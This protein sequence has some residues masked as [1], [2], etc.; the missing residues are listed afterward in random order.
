MLPLSIVKVSFCLLGL[1]SVLFYKARQVQKIDKTYIF[2]SFLL[3]FFACNEG[4]MTGEELV[5][6]KIGDGLI[7]KGAMNRKTVHQVLV[8]QACGDKRCFGEIAS[9]L[10]LVDEEDIFRYMNL[11]Y[12]ARC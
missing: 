4:K 6:E 1:Y 8:Y 11:K 5:R 3:V 12:A 2:N 9:S 10:K 7:R